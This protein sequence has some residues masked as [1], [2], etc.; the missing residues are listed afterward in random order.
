MTHLVSHRGAGA[1][2]AFD[3][4]AEASS[5]DVPQH[6]SRALFGL[7]SSIPSKE[8]QGIILVTMSASTVGALRR[9]LGKLNI[10]R[11]LKSWNIRILGI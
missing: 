11:S 3:E 4:A 8:P 1:A 10:G 5:G 2:C 9:M 6:K 7:L